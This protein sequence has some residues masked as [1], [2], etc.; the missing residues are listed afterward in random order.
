[1]NRTKP[2]WITPATEYG[3]LVLFFAVYYMQG[4]IAATVVLMAAAPIGIGVAYFYDRK[5]PVVP[6]IT[7]AV[8][9]FFGGL[10]LWLNDETF[11]KM[12]PTIIQSAFGLVLLGGLVFNK[13]LIKPLMEKAWKMTNEGWRVLTIRFAIYFFAMAALNEL[14]WRTQSTDFW[15]NFKVFGPMAMM[16]IFIFAQ[17]PV[18]RRYHIP[19][20]DEFSEKEPL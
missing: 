14:V 1:M 15:V 7:A 11:I 3:P 5:I 4:L 12:K 6:S 8:V 13:P 9:I 19:D 10:T 20:E 17:Y 18:I 16:I 2:G